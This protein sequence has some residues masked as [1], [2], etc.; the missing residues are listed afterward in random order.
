M[1]ILFRQLFDQVSSTYTYF[2][3]DEKSR[4]AVILD[5]VFELHARDLALVNELGLKVKFAMDT[6]CHA[7]HVT[8]AWLMKQATGCQIVLSKAYGAKNVDKEVGEGDTILIGERKLT[9]L[10][11]AGHTEG[12]L[13]FILDDR[14]MAFTGDCLMIRSAGRTDF[15]QGSAS[16]MF[17]SIRDKLFTLPDSCLIYPAHDYDGRMVSTIGEEKEYNTRIGGK[18][19][20]AD[21]VGL[22][23]NL[24]LPHPKKIDIA[25]PANMRCGMPE[26][27]IYPKLASW[28]PVEQTYDGVFQISTEW[29]VGHL[30]EVMVID[31]RTPDEWRNEPASFPGWVQIS[32]DDLTRNVE[33]LPK[34]K[35]II[36]VCRSGKRSAQ[37]VMLLRK[38]GFENT[39]NLKEGLFAWNKLY[40]PGEPIILTKGK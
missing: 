35:P 6:H 14:S 40:F 11:T 28:G 29:L 5:P 26:N 15:Q 24:N 18:A 10:S 25:L 32:L 2:L 31:V 36:T 13:T 33:S 9:V 4:E 20:E 8:G 38:K 12:C 16:K 37:A 30:S 19:N 7:D 21:F 3:A 34:T 27:G 1:S 39:A 23:K 17:H 22:M